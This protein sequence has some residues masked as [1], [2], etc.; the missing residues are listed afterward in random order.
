MLYWPRDFRYDIV[1]NIVQLKVFLF[2]KLFSYFYWSSYHL[3]SFPFRR[4]F[5]VFWHVYN[6]MKACSTA[7]KKQYGPIGTRKNLQERNV[8]PMTEAQSFSIVWRRMRVLRNEWKIVPVVYR[9]YEFYYHPKHLNS[10]NRMKCNG[11]VAGVQLSGWKYCRLL[12]SLMPKDIRQE[13]C[14]ILQCATRIVNDV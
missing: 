12:N 14:Y 6:Y 10:W 5:R 13:D 1:V 7:E 3:E 11:R 9:K 2:Q 4:W 8:K